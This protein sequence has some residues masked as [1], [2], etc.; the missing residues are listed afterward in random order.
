M[1]DRSRNAVARMLAAA[2][3]L[4]SERGFEATTTDA[5]AER[6]GLSVGSVYRFYPN[7]ASIMRALVDRHVEQIDEL[8]RSLE[9]GR[10]PDQSPEQE[11]HLGIEL[12]ASLLAN[13]QTFRAIWTSGHSS[14]ELVA[15][16][17]ELTQWGA[18]RVARLI[19]P[20]VAL[21]GSKLARVSLVV[22]E[23]TFAVLALT[24]FDARPEFAAGLVA[25]VKKLITGYLLP[26]LR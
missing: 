6:A 13:D 3:E 8:F 25:E 14:R 2:A 12:F 11:L 7:K 24:A 22:S 23:A 17:Y 10:R 19:G 16:G 9:A 4:F 18:S 5:I 21:E 26:Y 15:V 20:Y 1:Q